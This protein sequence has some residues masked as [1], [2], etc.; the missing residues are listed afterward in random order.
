MINQTTK[1]IVIIT[2]ILSVVINSYSQQNETKIHKLS[3]KDLQNVKTSS[4]TKIEENISDAPATIIIITREEIRQ[5]VYKDLSEIFEDLPGMDLARQ[6]GVHLFKN[7]IRGFLNSIGD[8]F[9]MMVDG[10]VQNTLYYG[11]NT[12]SMAAIPLSHIER[13]EVIYDPTS[14]VHAPN[15]SMGVINVIIDGGDGVTYSGDRMPSNTHWPRVS[16]DIFTKY[17]KSINDKLKTF[18]LLRYWFAGLENSHNSLT[19][20]SVSNSTN[21]TLFLAG[22]Y[23]YPGESVRV[24][25]HNHQQKLNRSL[26]ITQDFKYEYKDAQRGAGRTTNGYMFEVSVGAS[27]SDAYATAPAKWYRIHDPTIWQDYGLYLQTKYSLNPKNIF[28]LGIRIDNNSFYGTATT[29]RADFVKYMGDVTAKLLYREAYQEPQPRVVYGSWSGTG[30][31]P[32]LQPERSNTSE[33]NLNYSVKDFYTTLST[34]YIQNNNS[35]IAFKSGAPNIKKRNVLGL[36]LHINTEIPVSSIKQLRLWDYYSSILHE[37]EKKF[38]DAGNETGIGIIGDLSHHK[39]YM[40]ATAV[41]ID[42]LLLNIRGPYI[43]GKKTFDTNPV[44]KIE[45]YFLLERH[46]NYENIFD[47]S[48]GLGFKVTN[49]QDIKYFHS[50]VRDGN[51]GTEPGTWEGRS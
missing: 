15:A 11:I 6:H 5:R 25:K 8:P 2:T 36:D 40:G 28:N 45:G 31:S 48:I 32:Y 41:I 46:I 38:D 3:I 19:G 47:K 33:I 30:S 43:S 44:D 39:V 1:L 18:S 9:L 51:S 4:A 10:L 50:G 13:V 49:F 12:T 34:Y 23:V 26:L 37:E 16:R 24:A 42:N 29:L 17:H 7:Y 20:S 35:I 14:S 27:S 22:T 21:D